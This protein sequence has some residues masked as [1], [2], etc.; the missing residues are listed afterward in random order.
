MKKAYWFFGLLNLVLILLSVFFYYSTNSSKEKVTQDDKDKLYEL[1]MTLQE[2]RDNENNYSDTVDFYFTD[3]EDWDLYRALEI[4]KRNFPRF[5]DTNAPQLLVDLFKSK[6][7]MTFYK[8]VLGYDLFHGRTKIDTSGFSLHSFVNILLAN[9]GYDT[10]EGIMRAVIKNQIDTLRN[11]IHL[12]NTFEKHKTEFFD[13]IPKSFYN[14]VFKK[15]LTE[16]LNSYDYINTIEDQETYFDQLL[17]EA[18][19]RHMHYE[20]WDKTFWYRRKLENNKE[21]VYK[22]LSD[23]Q[24]HYQEIE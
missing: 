18:N 12:I 21:E 13:Y 24:E 14:K 7:E 15:Q 1:G 19:D 11:P 3:P 5:N 23:I 17:S 6:S 20:F 16:L 8:S 9:Q 2:A 10:S 22:I 4:E